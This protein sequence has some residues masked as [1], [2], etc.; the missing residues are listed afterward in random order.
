MDGEES[1]HVHCLDSDGVVA[2]SFPDPEI[3]WICDV[4]LRESVEVIYSVPHPARI[5]IDGGTNR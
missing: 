2:V 3:R 4:E 5:V 1:C